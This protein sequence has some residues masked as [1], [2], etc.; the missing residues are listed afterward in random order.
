MPEETVPAAVV[1]VELNSDCTVHNPTLQ[2]CALQ[3]LKC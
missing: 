3:T 1:A 2:L